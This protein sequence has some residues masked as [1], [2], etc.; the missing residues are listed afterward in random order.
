[1]GVSAGIGVSVGAGFCTGVGAVVNAGVGTAVGVEVLVVIYS[2]LR[3]RDDEGDGVMVGEGG[4][5][6]GVAA[7]GTGHTSSH[8]H[9]FQCMAYLVVSSAC[10]MMQLS[11]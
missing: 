7:S 10:Q 3:I 1:M 4:E 5:T 2:W 9:L 6:R 8:F 11:C